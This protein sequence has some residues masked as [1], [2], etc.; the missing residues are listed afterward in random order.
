MFC[1]TFYILPVLAIWILL[2]DCDFDY[3]AINCAA[4]GSTLLLGRNLADFYW[5]YYLL[6][7]FERGEI[8]KCYVNAKKNKKKT[9]RFHENF[10]FYL[11]KSRHC[12]ANITSVFLALLLNLSGLL[13]VMFPPIPVGWLV[14]LLV[15]Q[16]HYTKTT[17]QI[18]LKLGCG[19]WVLVQNRP[20]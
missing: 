2:L 4:Q 14:G 9:N 5:I 13:Q 1:D 18:S 20:R 11:S 19:R 12:F 6:T 10:T 8:S 15:C 7:L 3:F 16:Q 17:K